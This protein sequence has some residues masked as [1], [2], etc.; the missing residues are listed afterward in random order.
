MLMTANPVVAGVGAAL[1]V[2]VT[3]YENWDTISGWAESGADA[4]GDGVSAV[5]KGAGMIAGSLF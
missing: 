4:A 5:L 3:V 1:V 2:G